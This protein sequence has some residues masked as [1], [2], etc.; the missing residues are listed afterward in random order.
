MKHFAGSFPPALVPAM[1]STAPSSS[2]PPPHD[3]QALPA[4]LALPD[5]AAKSRSWGWMRAELPAWI[6]ASCQARGLGVTADRAALGRAYWAWVALLAGDPE[7]EAAHAVDFAHFAAGALLA[8]LVRERVLP[9]AHQDQGACVGVLTDLCMALLSAWRVALGEA[10]VARDPAL[11]ARHWSSFVEN[12]GTDP[13]LAVG[14]VDLFSG[15]EP[16][17]RFPL[18]P[19][20]RPGMQET[21]R[22]A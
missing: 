18:M 16:A 2:S 15:R 22:A 17:W 19:R 3:G 10:P 9:C 14:F 13:N 4:W 20:M 5:V 1:S 12:L 8:A 11:E 21:G 7:A 6:D